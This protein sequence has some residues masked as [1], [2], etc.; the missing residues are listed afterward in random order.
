VVHILTVDNSSKTERAPMV[1]SPMAIFL[2]VKGGCGVENIAL[3][4]Y[5]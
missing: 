1:P 2:R 3:V 4:M 5:G